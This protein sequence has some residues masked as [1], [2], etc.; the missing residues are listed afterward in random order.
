MIV[1]SYKQTQQVTALTQIIHHEKEYLNIYN[2]LYQHL[3]P[4]ISRSIHVLII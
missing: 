1:V 4:L 2:W 3:Q